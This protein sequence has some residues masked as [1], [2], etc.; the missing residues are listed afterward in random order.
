M[1]WPPGLECQY[2]LIFI[3]N[4]LSPTGMAYILQDCMYLNA[5]EDQYYSINAVLLTGLSSG[6]D[7]LVQ[8]LLWAAVCQGDVGTLTH[9]HGDK[10]LCHCNRACFWK[11]SHPTETTNSSQKNCINFATKLLIFPPYLCVCS[12]RTWRTLS[13]PSQPTVSN[14]TTSLRPTTCLRAATWLRSRRHSLRSLEWWVL[15][16]NKCWLSSSR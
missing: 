12:W 6:V 15:V 11:G 9:C 4:I 8:L 2:F 16:P 14:L 1:I 3:Y 13:K 10:I 5:R 7:R